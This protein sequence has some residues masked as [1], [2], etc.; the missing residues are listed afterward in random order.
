LFK[1]KGVR[2][3]L[4]AML[5]IVGV[6]EP[7]IDIKEYVYTVDSV[8]NPSTVS[9]SLADLPSAT[10][11]Y[12]NDGYPIAPK[13]TKKFYF[14]ISGSSDSG[15]AYLDLYR[16]VGFTVNRTEDNKKSWVK[17]GAVERKHY[18]TPNYYQRDSRLLINTKE[19]DATLD[20]ARGIEYDMYK[21]NVKYN[22]PI[23]DTGRTKPFIYVN[24][25]FTYGQSANTF[26]LTEVAQGDIQ[27]SFNGFTLKNG[28]DYNQISSTQIQL[29]GNVAKTYSNNSKDIITL[30]YANDK[31]NSGYYNQVSFV[32][33]NVVTNPS[34]LII[35]LPEAPLGEVQL[36]VNGVNLA[37]G[38]TLYTG[39]YIHNPSNSQELIVVN[40]DLMT[41]LQMNPIVVISYFKSTQAETL[42]KTSEVHRVD[43]YNTSK[44]FFNMS[45]NKYTYSMDYEAPDVEAIKVLVNGLTLQN[46]TD[47]ILNPSNKKQILFNTSAI[48]L[49]YII[50]VF[51]VIDSG[52][53][54][55]PISFGDF[56]FPDLS[57]ITFLEYL[58]LINRRLIN[59]KN[60]KTITDHNGGIYPTVQ[61]LYEEYLKRSHAQAPITPSNG[62]T[63]FN[64]YPFINKFNSYF[65][66]FVD[67]LLSGTIILKKGGVL[68]RNTAYSKQKFS[69]RRGVNFIPNLQYLGDDGSMFSVA[70]PAPT[71]NALYIYQKEENK[72][73]YIYQKDAH[74]PPYLYVKSEI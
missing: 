42:Q 12:D 47:F 5:L 62:Y 60:R 34:G 31:N 22:F 72:P 70:V 51:Y 66:K 45:L 63:F 73:L 44:F 29:I 71:A 8:I 56:D 20:I 48:N 54:E 2:D 18:T 6:P 61:K 53:I 39:D 7:F 49:G 74:R 28:A 27:V 40:N 13:E 15:Q 69:Y 68:I 17:E 26:T 14:Q 64:I 32:V 57:T 33:T 55:V 23:T 30:T 58:E 41:Y 10:L 25:P 59:V 43:S 1:S 65:Q 52:A 19:I 21:Y 24:I 37:K 46:G 35:P 50:H 3:A 4:K 67:Q 38:T 9:V 36:T 16:T 11:P